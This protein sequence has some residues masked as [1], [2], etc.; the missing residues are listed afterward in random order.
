MP[1]YGFKQ[2]SVDNWREPDPMLGIFVRLSPTRELR[3]PT[4]DER[5]QKL[6]ASAL[7]E[8]VPEDV[9]RLFEVARGTLLYGY[10][11]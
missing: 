3:R 9:R 5:A 8:Q 2:L 10:F 11:F 6:L 1:E 4:G 7:H